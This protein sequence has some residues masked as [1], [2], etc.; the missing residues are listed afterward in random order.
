METDNIV[1]TSGKKSRT[2]IVIIVVVIVALIA[3]GFLI[4]QGG[5]LTD[6]GPT[7]GNSSLMNATCDSLGLGA[8]PSGVPTS[9]VT[10]SGNSPATGSSSTSENSGSGSSN[11]SSSA[12]VYFLIIESDPGNPYAG[13]NGSALSSHPPTT[14]WPVMHVL[15]GQT[16]TIHILNCAS[17]EP[18]G[19]AIDHYF[20]NG[21]TTHPGGSRYVTFIADQTGTFRVYCNVYCSIHPLMQNG[22]LIVS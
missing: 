4:Y 22:E 3:I 16:V 6:S 19:F 12:H 14:Y 1:R 2:R 17:S 18:H 11:S 7:Y 21:L 13:M 20:N 5:Y 8:N 15:K 9:N 10:S